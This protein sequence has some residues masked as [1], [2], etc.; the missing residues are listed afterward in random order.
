MATI[1]SHQEHNSDQ[2]RDYDYERSIERLSKRLAYL[3][4]YGAIKEGLDVD[5]NGYVELKNLCSTNLLKNYPEEEVLKSIKSSTSNR[6]TKRYDCRERNG[7]TYV[8]A[9]YLR[10]FERSPYHGKTKVKTLFEVSIVCVLNNLEDFDLESF[11]EEHIL[12]NERNRVTTGTE[13][14]QGRNK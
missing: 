10:N 7:Q 11:P 13:N 12:S 4:R 1:Q 8:R 5:D 9:A 3:L 14:E 6:H 2:F